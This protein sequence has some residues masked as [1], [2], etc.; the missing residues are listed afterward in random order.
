LWGTRRKRKM[1]KRG[2]SQDQPVPCAGVVIHAKKRTG[3]VTLRRQLEKKEQWPLAQQ[4][5]GDPVMAKL[6]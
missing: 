3:G 1:L 2:R 5:I 4:N 6:S